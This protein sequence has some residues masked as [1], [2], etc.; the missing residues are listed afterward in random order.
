V[1]VA[2]VLIA[3]LRRRIRLEHLGRAAGAVVR[4]TLASILSAGVAFGV[5]YALDSW[6]GEGSI[7][8]LVAL[9]CGLAVGGIAYLAVARALGLREIE[10]LLL[11]RARRE[12]SSRE[13]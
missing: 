2:G 6:L 10:A 11:L 5:W 13:R 3:V 4:I 1:I 8:Q 7:A 9:G 12:D